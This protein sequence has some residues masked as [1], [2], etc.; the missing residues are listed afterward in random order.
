M[1]ETRTQIA[2]PSKLKIGAKSK[3]GESLVGA[4]VCLIKH[5]PTGMSTAECTFTSGSPLEY[6]Q[7]MGGVDDTLLHCTP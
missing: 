6:L 5:L 2:W 4:S 1:E 3:K 7:G